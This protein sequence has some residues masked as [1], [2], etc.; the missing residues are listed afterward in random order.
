M[1]QNLPYVLVLGPPLTYSEFQP[2]YSSSYNFLN[3]SSSPLPLL[4]F[5]AA[6]RVHPSS[7]RAILCNPLQRVTADVLRSLPSLGVVITTSVGTDHI[8]L[9]ECRRRGIRVATAGGLSTE[10]VADLAVG[11]LIDVLRRISASDRCVRKLIR[12]EFLNLPLGSQ[13]G[14]KRVGIV[15]LGKIGMEVAK[16]LEAFGCKILYHS[17]SK[18]PS[19]SY[20]FYSSIVEL[21]ASSDVLVVCCALTEESHHIIDRKVMLA[22]GKDGVIVNIGRGALIDEKELVQCLVEKEIGGAGLDVFENEPHVPKE[23]I[24]LDNVVLSPHA[25]SMTLE[26]FNHTMEIAAGNL[27]AFFSNK[28]LLTPLL[29]D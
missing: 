13:V 10:D 17:R 12:F 4:Q 27:E 29:D 16:R 23:L 15:G 25:A 14:G 24:S 1:A 6:H 8:D 5:L 28:P 7:I 9:S 22:L 3:L 11:L 2:R 20:P 18:K 19:V 26:S 21:A